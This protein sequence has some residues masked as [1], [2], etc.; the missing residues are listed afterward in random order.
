M[1]LGANWNEIAGTITFHGTED[2]PVN[3]MEGGAGLNQLVSANCGGD[4]LVR[5]ITRNNVDYPGNAITNHVTG[6]NTGYLGAI[7]VTTTGFSYD[8]NTGT[9]GYSNETRRNWMTLWIDSE[10]NLGGA[11]AAFAY[12]QL[13]LR[14]GGPLHVEGD[15]TIDDAN[16]GIY[17]EGAGFVSVADGATLTVTTPLTVDGTLVKRLSGTLAF[18]GTWRFDGDVNGVEPEL[19]HNRM[20][21]EEG[22]VKTLTGRAFDGAQFVVKGGAAIEIPADVDDSELRLRGLVL[23]KSPTI[24]PFAQEGDD[25]V[26]VI[27]TDADLSYDSVTNIPV[28]TVRS[29]FAD[30]VRS[31]LS[32][33]ADVEGALVSVEESETVVDEVPA[34]TFYAR[35]AR[36][37]G[38]F[39]EETVSTDIVLG[40]GDVVIAAS[41]DHAVEFTSLSARGGTFGLTSVTASGAPGTVVLSG[42][43]SVV[44]RPVRLTMDDTLVRPAAGTFW[45]VMRISD[46]LGSFAE[47]DFLLYWP[48]DDRT[49]AA[50]AYDAY[51]TVTH[52][53]GEYVVKIGFK[54][55]KT[56]TNGTGSSTSSKMT[57]DDGTENTADNPPSADYAYRVYDIKN[58]WLF[59][60]MHF[61]PQL[62]LFARTANEGCRLAPGGNG[63][64]LD[65][66]HLYS[67]SGI[68]ANGRKNVLNEVRGKITLHGS[69]RTNAVY[70]VHGAADAYL[71]VSASLH[72]DGPLRIAT[73]GVNTN[74]MANG[75]MIVIR[76][77]GDNRNWTGPLQVTC[78]GANIN[79]NNDTMAEYMKYENEFNAYDAASGEFKHL[80]PCPK[81]NGSVLCDRNTNWVVFPLLNENCLGGNPAELRRDQFLFGG[82]CRLEVTNDV[83]ICAPNRGVT[84]ESSPHI[85]VSEGATLK[86]ASP[87]CFAGTVWK[88]GA[89][90][91]NLGPQI[92]T[93]FVKN[94]SEPTGVPF[95]RYN[96]LRVEDG[97]LAV[98]SAKALDGVSVRMAE[99]T[100]V[101]IDWADADESLKTY[102][103]YNAKL[104]D[105]SQYAPFEWIA[106]AGLKFAVR[107]SGVDSVS[108]EKTY[109]IPLLTVR[110]SIADSVLSRIEAKIEMKGYDISPVQSETFSE[111]GVELTRFY[112]DCRGWRGMF[113]I[114]R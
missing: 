83:Q 59:G 63:A 46:S 6:A 35:I 1:S 84:F 49:G 110:S 89:G 28:V 61:I 51:L 31:A 43:S 96:R 69:N 12:N 47:D 112:V 19:Y 66:C 105:D 95:N 8:Y 41:P 20:R 32:V 29:S 9:Y 86:I 64:T 56:M 97:C 26:N 103:L 10:E 11:P 40:T 17:V 100:C 65:D 81:Q 77:S 5:F 37:S 25:K 62:S 94:R 85:V 79:R 42:S 22:R 82:A 44:S 54:P 101:V 4:G 87:L 2:Y 107:Y 57:W 70:F 102:G 27:V 78:S 39:Y 98:S 14:N 104:Q 38:R 88:D 75:N 71:D 114:W 3:F 72:G 36:L 55:I 33:S 52:E 58:F 68:I 16:R 93:L 45:T 21:I 67:G 91:L 50:G 99:G 13:R 34:T 30:A 73:Y 80:Y 90:T 7:D 15:V 48:G 76:L 113:L 106:D 24:A 74:N 23:V 92:E 18:G 108:G 53:G 111:D 109:R 60:S